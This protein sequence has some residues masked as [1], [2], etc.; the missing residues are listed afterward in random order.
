M[1]ACCCSWANHTATTQLPRCRFSV[2]RPFD[3]EQLTAGGGSIVTDSSSRSNVYYKTLIVGPQTCSHTANTQDYFG[4]KLTRT[5]L[6]L[7]QAPALA[8]A[9]GAMPPS[10]RTLQ[11]W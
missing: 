1:L 6:P 4:L 11:R 2:N 7:L 5:Q 3:F 8:R 9:R 10:L